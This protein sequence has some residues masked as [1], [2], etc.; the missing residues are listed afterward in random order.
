MI[1]T[2]R[3]EGKIEAKKYNINF[4]HLYLLWFA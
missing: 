3:K 2:R 4:K 1:Y